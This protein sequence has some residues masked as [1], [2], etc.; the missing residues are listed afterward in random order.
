MAG[1]YNHNITKLTDEFMEKTPGY[2]KL[3]VLG[4]VGPSVL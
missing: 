2:H 4:M 3:Y 1:A